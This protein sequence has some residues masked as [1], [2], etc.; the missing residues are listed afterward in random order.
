MDL[1][2]HRDIPEDFVSIA[3]T[4]DRAAKTIGVNFIGGYSALVMKGMTKADRL[5]I[6]SIPQALK[7]TDYVCSSI[8]VGSSR[9]GINMDAVLKMS[10][11]IKKSAGACLNSGGIWYGVELFSVPEIYIDD[12]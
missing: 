8:S 1:F 11:T 3:K 2:L 10:K 7:E 4:L 12:K 6:E 9:A 5:L